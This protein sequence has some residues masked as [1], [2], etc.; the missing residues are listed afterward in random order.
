MEYIISLCDDTNIEEALQ[1]VQEPHPV[2]CTHR[3]L[4]AWDEAL[5]HE[6]AHEPEHS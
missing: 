4:T 5:V 1:K 6:G 2:Y 3:G